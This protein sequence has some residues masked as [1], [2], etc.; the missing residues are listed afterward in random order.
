MRPVED[1]L[2]EGIDAGQF[3]GE[4]EPHGAHAMGFVS[5]LA[6]EGPTFSGHVVDIGSGAGLPALILA[7]AYA[8]TRW[9]LVERRSGRADL[10]KRAVRRLGLHDRVDV[11]SSDAAITGRT[12]L[13]GTADWVTAR[14]F[15]PPADT[16]ECAAPFLRAGGSLLTSEPFDTELKERWPTDGLD[17]AGLV[18]EEEWTTDAGRYVRFT[19]TT[20]LIEELPRSGARKQPIF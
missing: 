6:E 19:R 8:Q 4:L 11:V 14:S 1:I 16:A 15:G 2:R 5:F 20:S 10:L 17:R 9:T 13:R 7:D 3:G 18:F 12:P